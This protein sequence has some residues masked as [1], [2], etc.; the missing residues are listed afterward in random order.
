MSLKKAVRSGSGTVDVAAQKADFGDLIFM[1][2][3]IPYVKARKT[4]TNLPTVNK[5]GPT[6][7]N[8][9]SHSD[10][11]EE[12][13][14]EQLVKLDDSE[15]SDTLSETVSLES[16]NPRKRESRTISEVTGRQKWQKI[17]PDLEEQEVKFMKMMENAGKSDSK[18]DEREDELDLFGK[19]VAS[20]L[21][22]MSR[23]DQYVAK[24]QIQGVLF[25][26]Q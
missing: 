22:K 10:N 21:R 26:I 5:E 1:S 25:N 13:T 15:G 20:E 14:G 18:S 11:Y 24:H 8:C 16:N 23:H 7:G 2:W 9:T 4:K 19:L 3:L 17:K 6:T 12:G